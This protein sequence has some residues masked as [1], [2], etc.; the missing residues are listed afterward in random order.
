MSQPNSP[1]FPYSSSAYSPTPTSPTFED[2]LRR[3]LPSTPKKKRPAPLQDLNSLRGE[4]GEYLLFATVHL[5]MQRVTDH[6]FAHIDA[7]I[8]LLDQGTH[9]FNP[10]WTPCSTSPLCSE[11]QTPETPLQFQFPRRHPSMT[12]KKEPF[13]SL[14]NASVPSLAFARKHSKQ[15]EQLHISAPIHG[16]GINGGVA[17]VVKPLQNDFHGRG[18]VSKPLQTREPSNVSRRPSFIKS[19]PVSRLFSTNNKSQVFSKPSPPKIVHHVPLDQ[20]SH[21][22]DNAEEELTD[23]YADS[24]SEDEFVSFQGCYESESQRVVL[25]GTPLS[26]PATPPQHSDER[27]NQLLPRGEPDALGPS[28]LAELLALKSSAQQLY[29]AAREPT[30]Q[31]SSSSSS[32]SSS[33]T[34]SNRPRKTTTTTRRK[35][36][37]VDDAAFASR[38]SVM[39]SHNASC[40]DLQHGSKSMYRNAR[41][42]QSVMHFANP[43]PFALGPTSTAAA[44]AASTRSPA[45][46]RSTGSTGSSSMDALQEEPSISGPPSPQMSASSAGERASQ[47]YSFPLPPL[48]HHSRTGSD[49]DTVSNLSDDTISIRQSTRSNGSNRSGSIP[50]TPATSHQQQQQQQQSPP[51][52]QVLIYELDV[53]SVLEP[54]SPR[55][56]VYLDLPPPPCTVQMHGSPTDKKAAARGFYQNQGATKSTWA[57]LTEKFVKPATAAVPPIPSLTEPLTKRDDGTHY[58]LDQPLPPTSIADGFYKNSTAARSTWQ[59]ITGK[60]RSGQPIQSVSNTPEKHRQQ[61]QQHRGG[62]KRLF[63]KLRS[64]APSVNQPRSRISAL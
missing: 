49:L 4:R 54:E 3:N 57:V 47:T 18:N 58:Q 30:Q 44:T 20:N 39:G 52:P 16:L 29:T 13:F 51:P 48:S 45:H 40:V 23:P 38:S 41:A 64:T 17:N 56:A 43:D 7:L 46:H 60:T 34:S 62:L 10:A 14:K 8:D 5:Q 50:I 12:T 28:T 11:P 9:Y 37:T 21:G 32:S 1:A 6:F 55:H 63:S 59:V 22:Q 2:G 26:P 61:Q 19:Q 42:T 15:G 25:R 35:A 53:A 24:E 36:I 31:A 33:S 27:R